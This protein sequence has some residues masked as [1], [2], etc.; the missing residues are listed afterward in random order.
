M[1]RR[2]WKIWGICILILLGYLNYKQQNM[3]VTI[4]K[5]GFD[6]ISENADWIFG[7]YSSGRIVHARQCLETSIG[8]DALTDI[9]PISLALIIVSLTAGI[10]GGYALRDDDNIE[11]H[12]RQLA[13][14]DQHYQRYI[15]VADNK[16][17][18]AEI[19]DQNSRQRF[20]E[21]TQKQK[22]A[23]HQLADMGKYVQEMESELTAKIEAAE[24]QLL[25]LQEDHKKRGQMVDRLK[26]E[27]TDLKLE[28]TALKKEKLLLAQENLKLSEEVQTIKKN[29]L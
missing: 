29:I 28:N 8:W 9:W 7:K 3:V 1:I 14:K 12:K 6:N 27:K 4:V 16:R 2:H 22:L 18:Q 17:S 21:A 5:P 15:E 25:H 10:A 26:D 20:N 11:R 13:E 24:K 23:D 19:M